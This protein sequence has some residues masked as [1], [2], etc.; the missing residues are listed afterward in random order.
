M[1]VEVDY[2]CYGYQN[3]NCIHICFYSLPQIIG[4]SLCIVKETV[5]FFKFLNKYLQDSVFSLRVIILIALF[6]I[7]KILVLSVVSPEYYSIL[8][9]RVKLDIVSHFHYFLRHVGFN[10]SEWTKRC[11]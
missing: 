8:H 4:V 1:L 2:L 10:R 5:I 3:L 6:C 9:T 11:T 7:L